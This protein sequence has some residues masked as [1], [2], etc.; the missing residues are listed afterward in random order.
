MAGAI[1]HSLFS[2]LKLGVVF[3]Q[4]ILSVEAANINFDVL[5]N[6]YNFPDPS[7]LNYEGVSYV[8]ATND[9]NGNNIPVASNPDFNDPSGW[10]EVTD[11]FPTDGVPVFGDNGWAVEGTTWAPDVQHLV[12]DIP[13][14]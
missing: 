6:N 7:I 11:A 12:R 14:K 1:M 5:G 10:S 8:F 4:A 13:P 3:S 9:G 2:T